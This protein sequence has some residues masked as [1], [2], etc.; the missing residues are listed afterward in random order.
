MNTPSPVRERRDRKALEERRKEAGRMF[1][2]GATQAEVARRFKVSRMAVSKW[3]ASWDKEGMEGLVSRG[4]PGKDPRLTPQNIVTV[5]RA[6]LKG[7]RNAGYA[8][9]LWTLSRLTRLIRDVVC[10]SY[11][12]SHVW[13][14]LQSMGFSA[15]MPSAKPKERNE[16]KIKAW[17]EIHWPAIQKR[18]SKPV[19][20]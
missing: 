14:I 8:T 11:H 19:A 13:K 6:I 17:K 3:H 1:R 18:G 20:A 5:R 9:D 15:Q 7:P 12:P 2:S 10:V 4:N 16:R